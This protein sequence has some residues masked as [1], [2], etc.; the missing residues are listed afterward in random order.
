MIKPKLLLVTNRCVAYHCIFY[1][2]Y[3]T[4]QELSNSRPFTAVRSHDALTQ[5][6]DH[7]IDSPRLLKFP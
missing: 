3:L 5:V 7:D 4:K 1:P 2:I 6:Y